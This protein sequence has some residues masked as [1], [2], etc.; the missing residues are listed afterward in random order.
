MPVRCLLQPA[1]YNTDAQTS[2]DQEGETQEMDDGWRDACR[3][4]ALT[5]YTTHHAAGVV[6]T[7]AKL[8]PVER[9]K[10][11]TFSVQMLIKV[12]PVCALLSPHRERQRWGE[13][14]V[15]GHTE[16]GAC[17]GSLGNVP[18]PRQLYLLLGHEAAR[19]LLSDVYL[20]LSSC[21]TVR[22]SYILFYIRISHGSGWP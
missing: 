9:E 19:R 21:Q 4:D 20:G 3:R 18:S 14:W 13:C 1:P 22:T 10:V 7:A 15:V 16:A 5:M 17:L 2:A 6:H 11:C 12:F 8:L